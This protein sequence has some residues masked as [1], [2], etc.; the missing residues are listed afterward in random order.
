MDPEHIKFLRG[1]S[2]QKE[3]WQIYAHLDIENIQADYL[4]CMPSLL[5]K[6]PAEQ[7]TLTGTPVK[8]SSFYQ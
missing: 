2:R 8:I 6:L 5:S 7:Q 1:D 3:A 4:R